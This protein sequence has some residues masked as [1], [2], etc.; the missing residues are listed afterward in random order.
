MCVCVW[1]GG[2]GGGRGQLQKSK[3]IEISSVFSTLSLGNTHAGKFICILVK[4][5][6]R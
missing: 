2:G 5:H 4:R 3:A 1:G 6:F